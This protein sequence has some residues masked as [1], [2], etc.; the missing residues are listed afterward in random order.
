MIPDGTPRMDAFSR[1]ALLLGQ[2]A[3]KRLHASR[4]AV[5]GLGG[6][7]SY[8]V[9]ALAR[10]GV[11]RFLLVD[12]D[13]ISVSNLNRQILALHSTLG[14]LKTEVAAERVRD[15]NP[16][17]EVE[18]RALFYLPETADAIDLAACDYVVDAVDTVSA[19]VTL[20]VCAAEAGVPIVSCMGAGN[21]LDPMRFEVADLFATSVCPLCKVMRREMKARG[22]R[23]LRVVYSREPPLLPASGEDAAYAECRRPTGSVPSVP[24]AAGLLLAAEVI[25]SLT[26]AGDLERMKRKGRACAPGESPQHTEGI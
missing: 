12:H 1:T 3:I 15:I 23:A 22:I 8:V 24:A 2:P 10:A 26:D 21:K 9:E 6:V 19:K 5:F 18:T 20:A 4:V 14:R 7:G 16:R 13:R 25:R 11:G 17:A